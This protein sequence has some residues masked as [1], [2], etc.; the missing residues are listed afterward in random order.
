MTHSLFKMWFHRS[1]IIAIWTSTCEA[2]LSFKS[3]IHNNGQNTSPLWYLFFNLIKQKAYPPMQ[4]PHIN[5][6]CQWYIIVYFSY[7][8]FISFDVFFMLFMQFTLCCTQYVPRDECAYRGIP[9]KSVSIICWTI[10][11]GKSE[12]T[13]PSSKVFSILSGILLI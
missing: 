12:S 3:S 7:E 9:E 1:E 10:S 13:L 6:S 11:C 4:T 5:N 2:G 8:V